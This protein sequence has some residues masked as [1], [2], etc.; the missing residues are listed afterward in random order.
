MAFNPKGAVPIQLDVKGSWVCEMAP[1]CLPPGVSPDNQEII[2][3]PG[4]AGS[5]PALQRVFQTPLP[6]GGPGNL[7]PT[8]VYGKSFVT[9]AGE[10]KNLY[11]DSNGILWLEDPI[12]NPGIYTNI[13][14]T[15]PGSFC[16]SITAFG[17]EYLAF[18]DGLHGSDFPLQYDGTNL[19][20]VTQDGPA[21]PPV[22]T[23]VTIPSSTMAAT[24]QRIDNIASVTTCNLQTDWDPP[25]DPRSWYEGIRVVLSAP[26]STL[27]IGQ[28]LTIAGNTYGSF[29]AD[30]TIMQVVSPS[31]FIC[32]AY[33]PLLHGGTG[34][35]ATFAAATMVRS[36]NLVTVS[37]AATHNLRPG[38]QAQIT[39]IP[40]AVIGTAI[41]SIVVN[42]ENQAGIATITT[43]SAHGLAPNSYVNIT[44]VPD[45]AIGGSITAW[46]LVVNGV[47]QGILSMTTNTAHGLQVGMILNVSVAG[48]A[49][50]ELAVN[51]IPTATTVT[52]LT[53]SLSAGSGTTNATL[54]LPFPLPAAYIGNPNGPVV[55]V[56]SCPTTTTFQIGFNFQD[57]TWTG[58]G[59]ITLPWNGTYYVI[60]TPSSTSFTYQQYGP[61]A[62]S[63]TT[64][65]VTP[66]GQI[67]PGLH[68]CR[69]FFITRQGQVT[70]PSP[71]VTFMAN[72]GQYVS[73]TNL[74]IG[75][76]NIVGRGLE[77]TGAQGSYFFYIPV[78]AQVNGQIVS[79]STVVNDNTTTTALFDFGDATLYSAQATSVPSYDIASQIVIDGALGFA[80][81]EQRLITFGQR[82]TVDNFLN[83]GF[84]GGP[85]GFTL[86][87]WTV[88]LSGA[89]GFQIVAGRTPC[90]CEFSFVG[91]ED[92]VAISQSAYQ[93]CYGA[94][95]LQPNTLYKIRLWISTNTLT[96]GLT[97]GP[98]LR[99]Y[100]TS[101][102]TSFSASLTITNSELSFSGSYVEGVFSLA[103][104]NA[105]PNDLVLTI[106]GNGGSGRSTLTID[107]IRIIDSETPYLDTEFLGSY[108]DNP[109]AFSGVTGLFGPPDDTHK[110]M[111]FAI[112]RNTPY[113]VTQDP[114][115]R[116]H[117]VTAGNT[118]PSGWD[119]A[120][121][122]SSCGALSAFCLTKSQSDNRSSSG[123][124]DWFAWASMSGP[125]IFGGSTAHKIGQEIQPAWYDETNTAWPQINMAAALTVWALNDPTT[126]T[127]EFGLPLASATAPTIIYTMNYRELDTAEAIASSPPF[128][129]SFAGRLI[130]TDN[131]RKWT[132]WN[133]AI[134]GAALMYR[135][136]GVLSTVHFGGNGQAYGAAAGYGNVYTMNPA[137]FTDDDYGQIYPYYVTHAMPD[138]GQEMGLQLD[139]GRKQLAYFAAMISGVANVTIT[140]LCDNLTNVWP[141]SVTRT[142]GTN[143]NFDLE[144]GGGN[145]MAQRMFFKISSSPLAGTTDNSFTLRK[146][147]A[148]FRKAKI[149]V[150][151]AAQ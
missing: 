94:P 35:T 147:T 76:S 91:P 38:Y 105:V 61:D 85:L 25:A 7:A 130:A 101:A 79:T 113:I 16:R 26:D 100:L 36:S 63:T 119:V 77:F 110:V 145:A 135:S 10:I 57:A 86:P 114:E 48:G 139:S 87:G 133:L 34:G 89:A 13:F 137:K 30:W 52:F 80:D 151:G 95:I 98:Y 32:Y 134:N 107:E 62:T 68:Q 54:T 150:R 71:P 9:P 78:A 115:G 40:A 129:P 20:R 93:D 45:Q 124:E 112:I 4:Y 3:A 99:A 56:L 55:Q 125:R 117:R 2:F 120:E 131:T 109:E 41:T 92:Q 31:E 82:N 97:N 67:S 81:Y 126:R 73:V 19:D 42:N 51:S 43:S 74:L 37:T 21:V 12:N 33:F 144:W 149:A 66:W 50:L 84:E 58:G 72:G 17:R 104:P 123:G 70:K 60:S 111:D 118:E 6:S 15:I 18:S 127:I 132:R 53:T 96:L 138:S 49:V 122:D 24:A 108:Q 5:R 146:L 83:L 88:V 46:S 141:F 142:P 8:D 14:E 1:D 143:P 121:A 103:L 64:G 69:Q 11:L 28:R 59:T 44:G 22:V 27:A 102:N 90:A 29:N 148:W 75:P 116:L 140:P 39:G 106:F 23:S 47:G 65:T 128:H 136:A